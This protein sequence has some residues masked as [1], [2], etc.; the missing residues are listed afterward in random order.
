MGA[1][2]ARYL[3]AGQMYAPYGRLV[4]LHTTIILGGVAIASTGAPVV[5]FAI[6]YVRRSGAWVRAD[7]VQVRRSG[8]GLMWV[9]K[10]RSGE[11]GVGEGVGGE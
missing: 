10:S 6:L 1:R 9:R 7:S 5:A 11:A 8:A 4:V 2:V 3:Y